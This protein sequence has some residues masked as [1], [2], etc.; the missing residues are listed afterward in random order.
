MALWS[1]HKNYMHVPG[2]YQDQAKAV[3]KELREN[4]IRN[5]FQEYTRTGYIY[6]QYSPLDGH[7]QRSHPFTGWSSLVTLIMAEKF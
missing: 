1:L 7:G 2:P 5:M 4:L 6:E 3:Y